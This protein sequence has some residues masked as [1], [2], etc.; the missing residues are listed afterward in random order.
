MI[1]IIVSCIFIWFIGIVVSLPFFYPD[2]PSTTI[3]WWPIWM[4]TV[5]PIILVKLL[6]RFGNHVIQEMVNTYKN[7]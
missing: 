4:V 7:F 1:P 3:L 5:F 6:W 2:D